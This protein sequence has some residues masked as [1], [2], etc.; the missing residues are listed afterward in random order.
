MIWTDE[1][2][3]WDIPR[4]CTASAD[5]LACMIYLAHMRHRFSGVRF[6]LASAAGLAVLSGYMVLTDGFDGALFNLFYAGSAALMLLLFL[7]VC[8]EPF[9]KLVY[10]CA[11]A[12]FVRGLCQFADVAAVHLV[13]IYIPWDAQY[14]CNDSVWAYLYALTFGLVWRLEMHGQQDNGLDPGARVSLTVAFMTFVFYVLSSISYAPFDT[15]FGGGNR[16][17]V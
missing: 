14:P 6:W 8:R 3:S 13:R 17:D 15:P 12:F 2:L 16:M 10:Y 4:I 7:L 1:I 9:W 11:R 5:W